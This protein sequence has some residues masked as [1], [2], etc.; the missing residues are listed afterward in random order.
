MDICESI[1]VK[2]TFKSIKLPKAAGRAPSN[3]FI[4]TFKISKLVNEPI[5]GGKFPWK[6]ICLQMVIS[7]VQ[8]IGKYKQK[9]TIS[10]SMSY[11]E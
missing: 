6:K 3:L 5:S 8:V 11:V 4:S 1:M 2:L 10:M 9:Q 7:Y